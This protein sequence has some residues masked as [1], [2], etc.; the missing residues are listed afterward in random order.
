VTEKRDVFS[1]GA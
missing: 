1:E